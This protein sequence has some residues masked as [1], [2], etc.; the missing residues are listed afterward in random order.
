MDGAAASAG[1]EAAPAGRGFADGEAGAVKAVE[2][3]RAGFVGDDGGDAGGFEAVSD[4]AGREQQ[5]GGDGDGAEA[6]EAEHG[7][8]PLGDAREHDEDGLA[9]LDAGGAEDVG[10]LRAQTGELGE[11]KSLLGAGGGVDAPEREG[12]GPEFRPAIH[13]VRR[14]VEMPRHAQ[15]HHDSREFSKTHLIQGHSRTPLTRSASV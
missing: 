1:V 14:E 10:G 8:P 12:V 6:D 7:D 4:L 3:G 9:A 5:S 2:L 15:I 11:G 13:H